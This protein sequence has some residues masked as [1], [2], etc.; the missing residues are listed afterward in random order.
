MHVFILLPGKVSLHN[1]QANHVGIFVVFGFLKNLKSIVIIF[2]TEFDVITEYPMIISDTHFT[3]GLPVT[4]VILL[5][6]FTQQFCFRYRF[7][8]FSIFGQSLNVMT[9]QL[10][11]FILF[12]TPCIPVHQLI[13]HNSQTIHFAQP[14]IIVEQFGISRFHLNRI[15]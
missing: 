11:T 9:P 15:I 14:I 7:V 4:A 6:I 2:N 12:I 3:A 1:I 5:C 13:S 8:L 10:I